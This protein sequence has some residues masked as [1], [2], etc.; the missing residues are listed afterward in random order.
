M[1]VLGSSS[2]VGSVRL[3]K[4]T[5]DD[6][7][8]VSGIVEVLYDGRW[9]PVCASANSTEV[10]AVTCEG[11]GFRREQASVISSSM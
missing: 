6:D 1:A 8:R 4:S 3:F 10:A 7:E 9:G 11:L 5:I 2:E